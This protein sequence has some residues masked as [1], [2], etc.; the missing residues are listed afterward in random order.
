MSYINFNIDDLK[1][2]PPIDN[3]APDIRDGDRRWSEVFEEAAKRFDHGHTASGLCLEISNI[4]G[5]GS[6]YNPEGSRQQDRMTG[7][8]SGLLGSRNWVRSWLEKQNPTFGYFY[9]NQLNPYRAAWARHLA[10]QFRSKGL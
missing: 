10:A 6:D 2:V 4:L 1:K 3:K 5:G 9:D 8:I 7:Y